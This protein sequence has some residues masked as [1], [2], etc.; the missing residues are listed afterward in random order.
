MEMKD[1]HMKKSWREVSIEDYYAIKDIIEDKARSATERDI[2]VMAI[3]AGITEE[4]AWNLTIPE[5]KELLKQSMWAN[6]F[7]IR[8]VDFNKIT[9][10]GRKFD[11]C[12]DLTKF[13]V[14]QYVDFQ[15]LWKDTPRRDYIGAILCCFI[16]PTGRQ[17]AAGYDIKELADFFYKN[18]DILTCQEIL[19]FFGRSCL[20][21][22]KAILICL[23]WM[24]KNQKRK[25]TANREEIIK[26]IEEAQKTILD[27]LAGWTMSPKPKA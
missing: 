11:V 7:K 8:D 18:L 19:S 14:A 24:K 17:Y 25:K 27:G 12:V 13:T 4:E 26:K 20:T 3:L 22:I 5:A 21:S 15:S 9:I 2:A 23:E 10:D 6:E 1:I 16:I